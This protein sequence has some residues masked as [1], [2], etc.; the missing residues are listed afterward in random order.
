MYTRYT[1]IL[2]VM[3]SLLLTISSRAEV[4][5]TVNKTV[6]SYTANPR[7]SDVLAPLA[8][9]ESWYW[10]STQLFRSN[11]TQARELRQQ[12]AKMLAIQSNQNNK[13]QSIYTAIVKQ[14]ENWEVADR[15]AI[16]IDFELARI[17]PKNNPLI[18]DGLYQILLSKRP[19][20][21]QVFGALDSELDLPYINNTCVEDIISKIALS[22]YADK[23]YVYVISLQGQIEKSPIAYWNN[24]CTILAPGSLIYIPLQ[25]SLFSKAHGTINNQILALAVNRVNIQ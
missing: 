14:L 12:I 13:Q 10:P 8:F 9:Q 17:S 6:Y 4:E 24:K 21:I 7:L 15:I 16:E 2:F 5:V 25:E 11:T 22:D 1:F 19:T 20:N 18:E 3:G 23:S